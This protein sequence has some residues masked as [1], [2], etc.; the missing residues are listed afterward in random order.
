MR[1]KPETKIKEQLYKFLI[2]EIGGW[3]A[4]NTGSVF[5]RI[6]IPD[7]VGCPPSGLFCAFETK[8][9]KGRMSR[10]QEIN[11]VEINK[12]KGFGIVVDEFGDKEK[13]T[14][15]ILLS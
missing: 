7:I 4:K 5:Q 12:T 10:L 2:E 6:G 1:K 11:L 9:K 3:W 13:K 14:L 8:T 15:K